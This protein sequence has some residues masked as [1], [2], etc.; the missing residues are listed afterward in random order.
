[1]KELQN[2]LQTE[3]LDTPALYQVISGILQKG[4]SLM[5]RLSPAFEALHYFFHQHF[6]G[7][8]EPEL[9]QNF[10]DDI[11]VSELSMKRSI[12][13]TNYLITQKLLLHGID[14]NGDFV[15]DALASINRSQID[16]NFELYTRFMGKLFANFEV[17]EEFVPGNVTTL[18]IPGAGKCITGSTCGF[19]FFLFRLCQ[20]Q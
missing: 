4:H 20:R 7:Q 17:I 15:K 18:K 19:T 11:K 16:A 2:Q 8:L 6:G 3:S 1:M 13:F 12:A 5:L 9:T 10:P 14:R